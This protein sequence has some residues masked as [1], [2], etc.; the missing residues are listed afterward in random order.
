MTPHLLFT[1]AYARKI[2]LNLSKTKINFISEIAR[3]EKLI[4]SESCNKILM[5]V[6]MGLVERIDRQGCGKYKSKRT[7]Y[8]QLT[9]RGKNIT[10]LLIQLDKELEEVVK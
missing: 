1:S 2:L 9:K 4:F 10:N 7:K 5:L 3:E 8:Y 6:G